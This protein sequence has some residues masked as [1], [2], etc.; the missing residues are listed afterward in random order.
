VLRVE[1]F[2][3]PAVDGQ[4]YSSWKFARA[5]SSPTHTY[6]SKTGGQFSSDNVASRLYELNYGEA[7]LSIDFLNTQ[8]GFTNFDY[9]TEA[10]LNSD[11]FKDLVVMIP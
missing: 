9:S 7:G 2:T 11:G 4:D 6:L 3:L 5:E 8:R 1:E 10:N